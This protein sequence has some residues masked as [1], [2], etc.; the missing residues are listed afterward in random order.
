MDF[1]E[2][3]GRRET[4]EGGEIGAFVKLGSRSLNGYERNKLYRNLGAG[5]GGVPQ[6]AD[7]GYLAG[8]DRL[9]DGRAAVA[10]DI[11]G[12]GDLDL[13]V[14]SFEH[15]VVLLVN[16]GGEAGN[17]LELSLTGTRTNRDAIGAKVFVDAGG[18]RG[19][20]EVTATAGYLA[21]QSLLCHFGLGEAKVAD[22]VE[23][24]W[25]SGQITALRGVRANQRLRVE[26]GGRVAPAEA[27]P[28]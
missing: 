12:D 28:P 2:S 6:F 3:V 22:A 26:E 15:P 13:I 7:F 20:R 27:P 4:N 5:A 24:L 19:T 11:D 18:R 25:P 1:V 14:Q 10:S 16:H 17:W 8:A 9:E 21:G 23:I